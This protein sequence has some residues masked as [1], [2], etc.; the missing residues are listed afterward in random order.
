MRVAETK[1]KI[2]M[3]AT[4]ID[5]HSFVLWSSYTKNRMK[6]GKTLKEATEMADYHFKKDIALAIVKA[7]F[8]IA[9]LEA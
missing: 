7:N 3:I 5:P 2:A 9:L 1:D 6:D 8:I 4:V